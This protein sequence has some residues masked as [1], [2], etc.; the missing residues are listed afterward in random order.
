MKLNDVFNKR[1]TEKDKRDERVIDYIYP[2]KI[3]MSEGAENAEALLT[4][5][6]GQATLEGGSA[7]IL[8]EGD[9]VLLDFGFEMQGGIQIVTNLWNC[10]PDNRATVRVRFGES[11]MECMS[12]SAPDKRGEKC[13]TND[14]AIRDSIYKLSWLGMTE[15]G[16]TGFRFV[17][18]DMLDKDVALPIK[19]VRAKFQYRDLDYLGTFE[20]NDERIND[21][22]KTAVYTVQLNM[23]EYVWDGIKRDRLVWIGDMHPETSTIQYVFGDCECVRKSLDLIRDNTPLPCVMNGIPAYSM[24]WLLIHHDRFLHYGDIEYL[25]QQHKYIAELMHHLSG[26]I[27]PDGEITIDNCFLDWPSSTNPEGQRAGVHAL[28]VMI[29]EAA[30]EIF[31]ALDDKE[32][33]QFALDCAK[34]LMKYNY[35]CNGLKQALS[36][37]VLAGLRDANEAFDELL[38][39]NGVHGFSTFL[40]YYILKAMGEAEKMDFALDCIRQYWGA[41]LDLGATTFWEDFDIDWTKNCSKLDEILGENSDKDDIH[42]DFGGYCYKG[43][44]HSL[45]HGW[46]SGPAPFLMEYV[47]G[48]KPLKAG[49]KMISIAPQLGNLEYAKGTVPTPYGLVT[50]SHRRLENGEI[51]TEYTAPDEIEVVLG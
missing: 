19:C 9:Y 47:L 39:K 35:D 29:C 31:E 32:E 25:E 23:Q 26:F 17:R 46:A 16:N 20:C 38:G 12:E 40:G 28:L 42:G 21:I 30:A 34:E 49:S 15:I 11:A 33:M 45:C 7:C 37:Q 3:I 27:G 48:V 14:H 2:K 24:W 36:L 1:F 43:Y 18:I 51:E 4:S 6:E 10:G 22:W 50:V 13:A 44:R 5:E 41:M 8:R